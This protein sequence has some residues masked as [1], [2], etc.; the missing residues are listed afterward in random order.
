MHLDLADLVEMVVDEE[1]LQEGVIRCITSGLWDAIMWTPIHFPRAF[2]LVSWRTRTHYLH[3][4][5]G[6]A[7]DNLRSFFLYSDIPKLPD[8]DL[9]Q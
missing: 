7:I 5:L 6:I 9:T 4:Q 8:N 1:S 2:A 3:A